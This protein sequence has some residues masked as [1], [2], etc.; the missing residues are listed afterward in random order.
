MNS[1]QLEQI[2]LDAVGPNVIVNVW[3][4]PIYPHIILAVTVQEDGDAVTYEND[5]YELEVAAARAP[6]RARL[7]A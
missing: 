7:P 4:H 1:Q 5:E 3:E 6:R 2:A